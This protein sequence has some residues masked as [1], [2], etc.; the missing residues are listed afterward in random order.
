MAVHMHTWSGDYIL[1]AHIYR[2][3]FGRSYLQLFA[4][5]R[6]HMTVIFLG[7]AFLPIVWCYF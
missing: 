4:M 2:T 5:S 1:G 3:H 7:W 6:G